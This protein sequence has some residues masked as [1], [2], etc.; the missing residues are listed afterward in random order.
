MAQELIFTSVPKGLK[1]GS[2]GYCTVAYTNGMPVNLIKILE[3]FSDYSFLNLDSKDLKLSP[4][5]FRHY[6]QTLGTQNYNILS[7]VAYSGFDYTKR[8]NK[9]AYHVVLNTDERCLGGPAWM[10][11][12]QERPLFKTEWNEE[13]ALI[14]HE[15]S[16]PQGSDELDGGLETWK[17]LAEDAGWAGKLVEQYLENPTKPSY[18]VY[19][20]EYADKMLELIREALLLIPEK[21]R[22]QVTYNTYFT[23]VRGAECIWRCC[24]NG[25]NVLSKARGIPGTLIIDLTTDL[26]Q[27]QGGELI[28]MARKGEKARKKKQDAKPIS[29]TSEKAI[30]I[31]SEN[32]GK[33][34]EMPKLSLNM[35]QV[36]Q[37]GV[38]KEKSV[39]PEIETPK[40][41]DAQLEKIITPT[42]TGEMPKVSSPAVADKKKVV[43][44]PKGSSHQKPNFQ[45]ALMIFGGIVIIILLIIIAFLLKDSD[46]EKKDFSSGNRP[47]KNVKDIKTV[48]KIPEKNQEEAPVKT[49]SAPKKIEK[50]TVITPKQKSKKPIVPP[51]PKE[52]VAKVTPKEKIDKKISDEK[53]IQP[54]KLD[55]W[56]PY[57]K[58]IQDEAQKEIKIPLP[59]FDLNTKMD[60]VFKKGKLESLKNSMEEKPI[61]HE[62][63]KIIICGEKQKGAF[64]TAI[65]YC[66]FSISSSK[67]KGVD[68]VIEKLSKEVKPL[69]LSRD[70][71]AIKLG[72][73]EFPLIYQGQFQ[74]SEGKGEC[75]MKDAFKSYSIRFKYKFTDVDKLAGI[76]PSQ[77]GDNNNFKIIPHQGDKIL[78]LLPKVSS[79]T[80]TYTVAVS[81]HNPEF[82]KVFDLWSQNHQ[83]KI[84]KE[85]AFILT[86]VKKIPRYKNYRDKEILEAKRLEA[87]KQEFNDEF[88]EKSNIKPFQSLDEIKE[89]A[90]KAKDSVDGLEDKYFKDL[91]KKLRRAFNSFIDSV[92][93]AKKKIKETDLNKLQKERIALKKIKRR[94]RK[95]KKKPKSF[96]LDHIDDYTKD[97]Q[98]YCKSFNAVKIKKELNKKNYYKNINSAIDSYLKKNVAKQSMFSQFAADIEGNK[99]LKERLEKIIKE[100]QNNFYLEVKNIKNEKTVKNIKF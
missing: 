74:L 56:L 8:S 59:G 31:F 70:V 66:E 1:A 43:I 47:G 55:L 36:A 75:D 76:V 13:P 52:S 51:K 65:K 90:E 49:L 50:T 63:N 95:G 67:S 68:L 20:L 94:E 32:K 84:K 29:R 12:Q 22:W 46:G 53:K 35:D 97:I 60:L 10:S 26:P 9:L 83:N 23:V 57:Q 88:K 25:A 17:D 14:D 100:T 27:A 33:V 80:I 62:G 39:K 40:Q 64:R 73:K 78:N 16:V 3:S 19:D 42:G 38:S 91:K 11:W 7:R 5:S 18:I 98:D 58:G 86:Q 37:D 89:T 45:M 81:K 6:R 34:M 92:D 82:K 77:V 48:E 24:L 44:P 30:S 93:K 96:N 54:K 61:V 69:D 21:K 4:V 2:D 87:I 15:K 72:N 71:W 41:I 99:K 28:E 79:G 85:K